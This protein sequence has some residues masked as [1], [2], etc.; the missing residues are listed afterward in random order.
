MLR[1]ISLLL[2]VAVLGLGLMAFAGCGDDDEGSGGGSSTTEE[3]ST[4]EAEETQAAEETP[5]AEPTEESGG[6]A[7][8]PAN[9]DQAIEQ[10]KSAFTS[11]A[12]QVPA[13][14]QGD[15]DD[16]CEKAASGDTQGAQEA[17]KAVCKK[18][19]EANVPEG[20]PADVLAQGIEAC[21]SA[22][23]QG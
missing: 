3:T 12:P 11:A 10:C 16:L 22:V 4:P 15:I 17:A 19:I 2:L 8:A 7:A 6:G 20:T 23:P 5:E 13:D 14:A 9:A 18:L 1:K 21:E